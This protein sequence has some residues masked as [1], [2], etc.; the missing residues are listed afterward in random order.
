MK[1]TYRISQLFFL[2]VDYVLILTKYWLG[3]F[4]DDFFTNTSGHPDSKRPCRL[5]CDKQNTF[6]YNAPETTKCVQNIEIH[7][8]PRALGGVAQWTPHPPQEREDPGSSPAR[9]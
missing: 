3:Y 2:S 8:I 7:N 4:G 5:F 9:V 1:K 6:G